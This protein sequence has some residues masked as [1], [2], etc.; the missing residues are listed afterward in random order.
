MSEPQYHQVTRNAR[1]ISRG[2]KSRIR[3]I[4]AARCMLATEIVCADLLHPVN[5]A[6]EELRFIEADLNFELDNF[7]RK[8]GLEPQT[9]P[10][11]RR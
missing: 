8:W 7:N 4:T 6:I 10:K 1:D 5:I 11:G 2:M 9:P 3:Q